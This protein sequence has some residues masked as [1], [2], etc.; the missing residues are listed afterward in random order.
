MDI[1]F[2]TYRCPDHE[3][4]SFGIKEP[5]PKTYVGFMVKPL[6]PR[7]VRTTADE[8]IEVTSVNSNISRCEQL[9]TSSCDSTV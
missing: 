7:P 2:G 4:E 8:D 3:P 5:S 6:M 9:A 1:L